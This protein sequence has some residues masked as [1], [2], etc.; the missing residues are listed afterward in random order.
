L[1]GNSDLVA[2]PLAGDLTLELSWL[3]DPEIDWRDPAPR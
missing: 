1:L 3:P 2:D